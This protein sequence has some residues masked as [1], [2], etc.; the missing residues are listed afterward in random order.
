MASFD[1]APLALREACP[2]P[3]E[4]LRTNGMRA[5]P[6]VLSEAKV[7]GRHA[8]LTEDLHGL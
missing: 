5:F 4:G 7:E 8:G 6:F 2:E 3:V 1:F